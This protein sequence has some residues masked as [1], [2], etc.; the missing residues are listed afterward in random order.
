MEKPALDV[1]KSS[2]IVPGYVEER[3][4]VLEKKSEEYTSSPR[5]SSLT[6]NRR[7]NGHPG[8]ETINEKAELVE[9]ETKYA[10]GLALYLTV[11]GLSLS[12]L[13]LG[14]VK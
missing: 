4:E 5:E 12:V 3:H 9:E 13:L 8:E 11:L 14:L 1:S 10:T 6:L 7:L 2:S